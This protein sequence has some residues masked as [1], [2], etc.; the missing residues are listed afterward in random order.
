MRSTAPSKYHDILIPDFPL[1]CKRR[2]F[3]P[4]YLESLHSDNVELSTERILEFYETGLRTDK[5]KIEADTVILS[6]GFKI[7]EFLSPV[8]IVG[9]DNI[10]LNDH[11]KDTR[12]AQAYK[13]TFVSGF[14]NFGIVFGPNSFPAHNSVIYTNEVQV[15]FIIK[16][17]FRPIIKGNFRAI[18]V[19]MSAEDKDASQIQSKLKVMVWSG[20]C[21]N[22]N[23][24][25]NGRNTTNYHG[26]TWKF[27]YELYWPSWRDFD[28]WADTEK[29]PMHPIYKA[30]GSAAVFS[31][32]LGLISLGKDELL[33][34]GAPLARWASDL[35]VSR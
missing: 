14:P 21:S 33:A 31:L 10:S 18:D 30:M 27:W 29:R 13:A 1:G 24:D 35:R 32:A 17:I 25:R 20:G 3:D 16:T 6:T 4:G 34:S 23:L 26:N 5:R 2:I 7:Q 28:T 8:Q 12:G 22:W 9:R 11:W 19:K 15:E